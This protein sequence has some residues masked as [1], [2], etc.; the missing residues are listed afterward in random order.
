MREPIEDELFKKGILIVPDFVANMG[1]VISSY[2]EYLGINPKD[3][4]LELIKRKVT[5]TTKLILEESKKTGVAP[6]QVALK[7]AQ[8]K[9]RTKMNQNK[10]S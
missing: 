8:D 5:R 6:R 1:G 10:D 2:V 7:L 9:L 4:M 3:D